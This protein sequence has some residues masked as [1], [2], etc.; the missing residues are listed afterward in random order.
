MLVYQYSGGMD[1]FL[2]A[3][4]RIYEEKTVPD[5]ITCGEAVEYPLSATTVFIQPEEKKA[6]RVVK[7]IHARLGE[8]GLLQLN[9]AYAS[10]DPERNRKMLYWILSVFKYG[11]DV[12]KRYQDPNVMAFCDMTARVTL[13]LNHTMGYVRFEESRE[14]LYCARFAPDNNVLS[15]LMPHFAKRFN[16]QNFLIFDCKRMLY[17]IYN[18]REWKVVS[19]DQ[20]VRWTPTE[21]EILFQTLWKDY[22]RAVTIAQRE[23]KKLQNSFLPRRYREYMTEFRPTL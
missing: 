5:L 18:G 11:T 17:G 2:T 16:D 7:G 8:S 21:A 9:Y 13:E 10:C 19:S 6:L 20:T 12:Q 3:V 22:F 15:F 4:F 23:N 14:G 1:G